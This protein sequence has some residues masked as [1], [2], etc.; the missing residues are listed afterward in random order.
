MTEKRLKEAFSAAAKEQVLP[1]SPS[2]YFYV[3]L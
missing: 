2:L 3:C 1:P